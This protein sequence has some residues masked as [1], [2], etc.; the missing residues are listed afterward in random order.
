MSHSFIPPSGASSWTKCAQWSTMN[1]LYPQD[2]T[3]QTLGGT[4]AHYV[5][6]EMFAGRVLPEGSLTPNGQAVTA[7][8]L[9]GAE[10]VCDV[11]RERC[12]GPEPVNVETLVAV[13]R[14]HPEC[15]GTADYWQYRVGSAHLEVIDYKFGHRY[16]DEWWNPQGLIYTFGILDS[17]QIINPDLVTVSFTIVQP[18][19]YYRG[20]SV[21]THSF[22]MREAMAHLPGLQSAAAY[23]YNSKPTARTG[24]YCDDCSGRHACDALQFGAYRAAQMASDIQPVELTPQAAALELRM[25]ETAMSDL[26][27]RVNGL[28]EQTLARIQGGE[29]IPLY[30]LESGAGRSHWNIPVPQVIA[31]G[32]LLG[33][34][35]S[36]QEVITPVQAQKLGVDPDI[37]RAYSTHKPGSLRLIQT[38][39]SDAAKVF[40]R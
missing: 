9:D 13:P 35:L 24:P 4:A 5:A 27:A 32:E 21:R 40:G 18:R 1:R 38:N 16:I 30:R 19:C 36:K 15:F 25:L 12:T 29:N 28:R 20:R 7:E 10:L 17:L 23:C 3:P 37:I 6:N 14:V 31:I 8:M 11:I 34:Q 26:Q 2:D 39:D 22:T 33:K